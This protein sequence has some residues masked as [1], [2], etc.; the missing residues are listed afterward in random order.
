MS[1]YHYYVLLVCWYKAAAGAG[2]KC[3]SVCMIVEALSIV[4]GVA[5]HANQ[6]MKYLVSQSLLS[7]QCWATSLFD[8]DFR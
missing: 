7:D 3:F 8:L 1:G 2:D 5:Q 6:S 4:S